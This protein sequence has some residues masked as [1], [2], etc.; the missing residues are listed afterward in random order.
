MLAHG[1]AVQAIRAKAKPGTKVGPAENIDTAVP[2]IESPEHI[3]AAQLATR[4]LNAPFLTVMLEGKY[5]DGYLRETGKDAPRF[6]DEDLRIIG[7]PLDFVG[8]NVY[9]PRSYVLASDRAPGWRA[10]PY[11]KGHAKAAISNFPIAPECL[12]WASKFVHSLW[13]AKE[14]FITENGCAGEDVLVEDGNIYD[15]DRIMFIRAHL[16]QLQRAGADGACQGLFLLEHDGQSG[17]DCRLR[18]SLRLGVRGLRDAE[19][20]A[21]AERVLVSRGGAAQRGGVI[22]LSIL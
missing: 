12:Y 14:I 16:T 13:G 6:T 3:A 15:T 18:Q 2:L 21:E 7:A 1:L 22:A 11:A 9:A 20:H 8:F 5:T 4:E 17:V 19:A 10:V